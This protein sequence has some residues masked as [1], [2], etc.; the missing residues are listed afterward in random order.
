MKTC[1]AG[2]ILHI[3][4]GTVTEISCSTMASSFFIN[5]IYT[6]QHYD[7]LPGFFGIEAVVSPDR[8]NVT[9]RTNGSEH[10]S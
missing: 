6:S 9:L 8:S 2:K 10:L 4:E 5:G 7:Q 3:F 1:M